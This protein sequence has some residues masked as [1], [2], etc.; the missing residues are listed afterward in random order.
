MESLKL[1]TTSF[2]IFL[3]LALNCSFL[4]AK[5][6]CFKLFKNKQ[7]DFREGKSWDTW[8]ARDANTET[9]HSYSQWVPK[10]KFSKNSFSFHNTAEIY[11]RVSYD[12][13]TW[14]N[15]GLINLNYSPK[16]V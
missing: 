13:V 14:K 10:N 5:T 1:R 4:E 12:G 15:K 7:K 8:W 3:A 16:K 2:Y 9:I 11:H 6:S